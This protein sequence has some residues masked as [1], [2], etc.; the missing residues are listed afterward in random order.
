M[1]L[2]K[3]EELKGNEK[4]GKH[5]LTESGMELMAKGSVLKLEYIQKLKELAIEYVFIDDTSF[6]EIEFSNES[7]GII[8]EKVREE[9][10]E[11]VKNVLERHIYR[12]SSDLEKL[13]QAANIIVEDILSEDEIME[14]IANIRKEGTDIYSHSINVCSL[15]TVMALKNSYDRE[16]VMEVAK[17]CILHDI[18]LRYTT[19]NY[20]NVNVDDMNQKER[21]EFRKHVILGFDAIKDEIWASQIVKDI[22]LLHHER[23]DGT[24]YPFKN[25]A[26]DINDIVK[27]VEVCD[28]FDAMIN[29]IG[30][31]QMKVHQA[32]EYIKSKSLTAFEKKY[33][34][35]LLAM[36]AMYPIGTKVVTSEDEVG[37]VIK[38]N[39]ECIDRPVLRIIAR[40]DGVKLEGVV[41]DMTEHLTM[42]IV[43]TLD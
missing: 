15:A 38:Q 5:I 18:G 35:Q 43:D 37:I 36:V 20:E 22:V 12:N 9:S 24:G 6:L 30:H 11:L 17:G 39:K 4:L 41:K 27:I 14:K 29:G 8:K 40:A 3:L 25:H 26:K 23:N 32:V 1:K 31:E 19:V 2:V 16:T 10:K 13:C 33:A 21:S 7:Q 34:D 28:A 42:F